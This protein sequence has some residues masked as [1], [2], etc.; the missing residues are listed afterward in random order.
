MQLSRVS[1]TAAAIAFLAATAFVSPASA[2]RLGFLYHDGSF[3][4]LIVPGATGE[5]L[6][7]AFALNNEDEIVGRY[8]TGSTSRSFIYA[9][10]IYTTLDGPLAASGSEATGIND[11]GAI[12]GSYTVGSNIY[13][14]IYSNGAYTTLRDPNTTIQNINNGTGMIT[15]AL[16][17]NDEGDVVGV[18]FG[19]E[20]IESY[21]YHDGTYRTVVDPQAQGNTQAYGINNEGQIVGWYS[22]GAVGSKGFLYHGGE[23]QTLP[24]IAYG[25]NDFGDMVGVNG[26]LSGDN[27]NGFIFNGSS[28]IALDDP[29]SPNA[30]HPFE[31]NDLGDVV[32]YYNNVSSVPEPPT[33][34]L[35][36]VGLAGILGLLSRFGLTAGVPSRTSYN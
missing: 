33:W 8:T 11:D 35:E 9:N 5:E 21:V 18:F 28:Y 26:D 25:I 34:A 4:T 1:S 19:S 7:V 32:G 15:T 3:T 23:Y 13:G 2:T 14:Y 24:Y 27:A 6:G 30:T 31:I 36:V 10:G 17:I 20:G 22:N 16:G 12:V 29:L